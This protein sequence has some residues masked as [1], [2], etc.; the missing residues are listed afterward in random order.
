[1]NENISEKTHWHLIDK[2]KRNSKLYTDLPKAIEREELRLHYQPKVDLVTGKVI[3]VEALVRWEHPKLGLIYPNDIIP[4]AEEL[5]EITSIGNWV[6]HQACLQNKKWQDNGYSPMI[7]SVNLSMQQFTSDDLVA[8]V[9]KVLN[10]TLLPAHYL[11]LEITESMTANVPATIHTLKRLKSLGIKISV[12]DFG[13]GYSNLAHLKNFPVDVLKIDQSFIKDLIQ[14]PIDQAIVKTI[15]HLASDL[16]LEVVAEGIETSDH[17]LF[18]KEHKCLIGQGY[19]FSKPVE[20]HTFIER[21]HYI[22]SGEY[23]NLK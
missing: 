22:E 7:M 3:G 9:K 1:M 23:R 18:L 19:L 4:V 10:D 16:N 21:V 17:Y 14:N 5:G 6:I 15:I 13:T 2:T 11:E 12:D 8:T 20:S